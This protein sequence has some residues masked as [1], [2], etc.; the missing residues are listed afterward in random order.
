M[1]FIN[2]SM[3]HNKI[4]EAAGQAVGSSLGDFK[5]ARHVIYLLVQSR[6]WM[7]TLLP[8]MPPAIVEHRRL[9]PGGGEAAESCRLNRPSQ[10]RML[11]NAWYSPERSM[12]RAS[13]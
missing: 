9:T 8:R 13:P 12:F 1:N 5:A 10:L 3:T 7:Q 2:H 4:K 11:Y 6:Y